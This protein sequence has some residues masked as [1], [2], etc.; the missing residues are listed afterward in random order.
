MMIV[1]PYNASETE[2][3]FKHNAA[4][5]SNDG[6]MFLTLLLESVVSL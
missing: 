6:I 3:L 5:L 4:I 2:N 1:K